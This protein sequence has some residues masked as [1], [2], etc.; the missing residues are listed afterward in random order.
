MMGCSRCMYSIANRGEGP[1]PEMYGQ[2]DKKTN[3]PGNSAVFAL[4]VSAAWFLYFYLSN[5]AGT[6]SGAFV[7]DPT[8]LPIITVYAMYI[9]IFVRWMRNEKSETTLR[10]YVFPTLAIIGSSFMVLASVI[11]HRFSCVWYLIVFAVIMAI[12]GAVD[13]AKKNH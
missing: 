13:K 5:L 11:S 2:V 4:I 10:R 6:W 7:F 1:D 12:G 8:E 3:M 9:P